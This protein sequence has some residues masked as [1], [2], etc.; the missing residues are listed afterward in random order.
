MLSFC[1]EAVNADTVRR[2]RHLHSA[3]PRKQICRVNSFIKLIF[4]G[5]GEGKQPWQPVCSTHHALKTF[6]LFGIRPSF[7]LLDHY[8]QSYMATTDESKVS[9]AETVI[10]NDRVLSR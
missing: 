9:L 6:P 3:P 8:C 7:D 10:T 1:D 5:R 4:S 2:V